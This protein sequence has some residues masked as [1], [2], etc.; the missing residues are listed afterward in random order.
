MNRDH[1]VK[2]LTDA[3][4]AGI[5]DAPDPSEVGNFGMPDDQITT[6]VDVTDFLGI[7]KDAMRAHASQITENSF[8]LTMPDDVFAATWGTEWFIRVGVDPSTRETSLFD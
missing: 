1:F 8:F 5:E 2:L 3:K 7:K 6:R 4:E